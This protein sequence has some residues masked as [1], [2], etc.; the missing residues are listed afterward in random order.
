M[1]SSSD[2][3]LEQQRARRASKAA[4]ARGVVEIADAPG[5]TTACSDKLT[6][7]S[8]RD[9]SGVTV[10]HADLDELVTS[11]DSVTGARIIFYEIS[12]L[13][14]RVTRGSASDYR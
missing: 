3:R 8:L 10:M 9:T 14:P 13:D 5:S 2:K 1:P 4:A 12:A 7:A 6:L 11:T